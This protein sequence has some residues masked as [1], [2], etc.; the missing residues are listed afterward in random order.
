M[1]RDLFHSISA[2]ADHL[3]EHLPGALRG[4]T[5]ETHQA[6]VAARRLVEV[7]PL[8]G[9]S[10]DRLARQVRSI[11]V[12]L[13]AGREVAVTIDLLAEEGA[14]HDWP[15]TLTARIKRHL[16]DA[17]ES[18]Q[19]A[20]QNELNK[21]EPAKLRRRL[22]DVASDAKALKSAIALERLDA[23]IARREGTLARAV[24]AAGGLYDVE[25]LHRIRIESK[26]L[27]YVLEVAAEVVGARSRRRLAA[28]KTV[29]ELLGRL[30]DLQT[31]QGHIREVEITFVPGRGGVARGLAQMA[32]DVEADCRAV[33][34][35]ALPLIQKLSRHR[36]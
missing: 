10:G 8:V 18:H 26:K 1:A 17:A 15:H 16:D 13:G 2:R 27:R 25:R 30:H 9:P 5:R 34:A 7:L 11:R 31:L 23:Q 19:A 21:L 6:R 14:R 35:A 36:E 29:Q 32:E 12:A 24:H 28:L 22:R 20:A 4:R 33:H 3:C